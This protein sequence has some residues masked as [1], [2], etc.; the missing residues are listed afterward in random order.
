MIKQGYVNRKL[1]WYCTECDWTT[2]A[3]RGS[4]PTDSSRDASDAHVCGMT[5]LPRR[6]HGGAGSDRNPYVVLRDD[7]SVRDLL[8]SAMNVAGA[9]M[10]NVQLFDSESQALKIVAHCGFDSEF[11]RF[12]EVVRQDG[13]SACA[14]AIQERRRTV[15][16]DITRSQLFQDPR[17]RRI[18]LRAGVLAVQSSPIITVAGEFLG[19]VSTHYSV[20]REDFSTATWESLDDVISRFVQEHPKAIRREGSIPA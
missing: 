2:P 19:V 17:V 15:V 20:P 9:E 1:I 4:A 11:L 18:M 12:F 6:V 16:P 13:Q 8:A 14:A 3:A 10:A 7:P 5:A